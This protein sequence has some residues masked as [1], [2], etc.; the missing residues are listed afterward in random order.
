[1]PKKVLFD[2]FRLTIYV[3]SRLQ[4][5]EASAM[6]RIL[7][8]VRFRTRLRRAVTAVFR[9]YRSLRPASFDVSG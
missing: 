5:T 2:Q 6:S 1:M 4:A 7:T 8:G 3:Q 9:G